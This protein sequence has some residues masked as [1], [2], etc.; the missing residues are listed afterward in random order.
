MTGATVE[1]PTHEMRPDVPLEVMPLTT[2]IS[3]RV[4]MSRSTVAWLMLTAPPVAALAAVD[5]PARLVDAVSFDLGGTAERPP[6]RITLYVPPGPAPAAGW[7]ILYLLDGNAVTGTAIDIE[8]VQAPYP[9][10]TGIGSR[11][12]I[13]GIGYPGDQAYDGLRR[14]WDYTP[15]PG[16]SY[17]PYRAD[18]PAVRTGGANPFLR[19]VIDE[20]KP[21]VERRCKGDPARQAL[22]GHSLGGLFVLYARAQAP[23]T[24]SHWIAASPSIYWEEFVLLTSI[25]A[26]EKSPPGK[27]HVLLMA[28]AYEAELAPFQ[29]TAPDHESRLARLKLARTV[30]AAR[31]L[32][33]RLGRI[34]GLKSEFRVIPGKTHMTVLP[35]AL[36]EA[37]TSF[38][39]R[40]G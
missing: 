18:G 25:D 11:F 34:P 30:E 3:R 23:A 29:R 31:T 37:V 33:D 28:G 6:W 15:P 26:L 24:F 40:A 27:A 35:E 2:L 32:S 7:P 5:E 39:G 12:A 38:L 16:K 4:F 20:L 8:R 14:S 19:F 9:D 21:A 17:P 36:N 1:R 13:V 10:G 22:F